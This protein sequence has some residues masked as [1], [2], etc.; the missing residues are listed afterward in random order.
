MTLEQT[1][2]ILRAREVPYH[3]GYAGLRAIGSEEDGN[4]L[5]NV[6]DLDQDEHKLYAAILGTFSPEE[7]RRKAEQLRET[8]CAGLLL[9]KMEWAATDHSSVPVLF[10]NEPI[11]KLLKLFVDKK[12]KCV[13][14]A[15]ACLRKRYPYQDF[16][17]QKRILKAFLENGS[18]DDADWAGKTLRD[19]W[20]PGFEESVLRRWTQTHSRNLGYTILRHLPAEVALREQEALSAATS[21]AHVAA[22]IGNEPGFILD[23]FRLSTP[24]YF[25]V[26]AKLGR[27]MSEKQALEE[28]ISYLSPLPS[29]VYFFSPGSGDWMPQL[30]DIPGV[31]IIIWSLGKLGLTDTL[32]WLLDV[33]SKIQEKLKGVDIIDRWPVL[34]AT[35]RCCLDPKLKEEEVLSQEK[36]HYQLCQN[37]D[38][39]L[40][41]DDLGG[42]LVPRFSEFI[43][44]F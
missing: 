40:P 8:D 29:M 24:D 12:S 5:A 27:K 38:D 3:G 25:Y 35:L 36:Q 26:M 33:K 1:I 16:A 14:H 39:D 10:H 13:S 4:L 41:P 20:I 44:E 32:I 11:G 17:T 31:P 28:L 30:T 6:L 22:R 18:K 34:T 19:N 21:Y 37:D 42:P 2:Q 43:D 23:R 7:L 9:S 15:R